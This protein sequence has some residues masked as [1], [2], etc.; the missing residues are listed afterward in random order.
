MYNIGKSRNTE[1][2]ER[3]SGLEHEH[4]KSVD[5]RSTFPL[6]ELPVVME[7]LFCELA[8]YPL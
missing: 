3:S 1:G 4:G 2:P 5:A 7:G 8:G 6:L